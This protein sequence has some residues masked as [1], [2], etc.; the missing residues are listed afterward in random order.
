AKGRLAEV[1]QVPKKIKNLFIT[2]LEIAP[3]RHLQIQKAF[4]QF[5]DN[6]VSKTINLP[7]DATIKD[8]ADSYLQAWRMGLKGITIYRYGSK[9][10]QV[11]NIGADEKAHYYDHSSRC[12]PDECRV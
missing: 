11:L 2:A 3:E 5:V 12:D 8:V 9:S 7:H 4:Q 1:E 10:V 6:S